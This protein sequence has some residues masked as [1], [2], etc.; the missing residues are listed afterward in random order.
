MLA[1]LV[2]RSNFWSALEVLH[3]FKSYI[4]KKITMPEIGN[5]K[6]YVR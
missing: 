2:I 3:F 4:N 6:A 1:L 5:V